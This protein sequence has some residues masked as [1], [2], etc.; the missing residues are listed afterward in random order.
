M[1]QEAKRRG[2][3]L[4]GQGPQKKRYCPHEPTEKQGKFLA[5]TTLEAFYG[6]AAGGGKSD[7]LLMAAL[8]YVD[9]PGYNALILRRTFRDLGQPGAIMTRAKEWLAG[10]DAKWNDNDKRFT[11]PSGA[12][13]TF[14]YLESEDDV[15]QYQGAEFQF[16]GFDELTQFTKFQYTYLLS[17]VRRVSGSDIPLR[18][19][20]AS[21]PGGKGHDWVFGRFVK[22]KD[23]KRPF[24]PARLEENPHLD[25][26]EYRESL[27]NLMEATRRQLEDGDWTKPDVGGALW[28]SK[29]FEAEGF[30]ISPIAKR[31]DNG[32][33]ELPP[34]IDRVVVAVD[35]TVTDYDDEEIEEAEEEGRD[36][37]YKGD[38]CGILVLGL[39][40]EAKGVVLADLTGLYS[41]S[42]WAQIAVKAYQMFQAMYIVVEVNQGGALV[43]KTILGRAPNANVLE[44]RAAIGKRARAEP[45]AAL[46]EEG[47]FV[48]AGLFSELEA[49]MTS[50]DAKAPGSKSPNRV[51]ALVWGAHGLGLCE[52]TGTKPKKRLKV[53]QGT[54]R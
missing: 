48:H 31:D 2:L 40:A 22:K 16:V 11:F 19:R 41:P 5:L 42:K 35:P 38:K 25:V 46:Y 7:A 4:P 1:E 27:G 21:N 12:T 44:V 37:G 26:D 9:R 30:R 50:W 45:V 6:G 52:A 54:S 24:V 8:E 29:T 33:I 43:K 15:Y 17:R 51:D 23:P 18:V 34:W 20:S 3:S 36:P 47:R 13:L 49:E 53:N 28:K 10:T 32:L 14:G 39:T